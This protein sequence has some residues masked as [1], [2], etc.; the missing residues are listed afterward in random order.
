MLVERPASGLGDDVAGSG[1]YS[2]VWGGFGRGYEFHTTS[3][4][5]ISRD[6]SGDCHAEMP[7][8]SVKKST[9]AV[10]QQRAVEA[11]RAAGLKKLQMWVPG[12]KLDAARAAVSA[13]IGGRNAPPEPFQVAPAISPE[14][15]EQLKKSLETAKNLKDDWRHRAMI[16]EARR[17]WFWWFL[18]LLLAGLAVWGWWPTV[19]GWWS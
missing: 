9:D 18:A 6:I 11:K 5:Y 14:E 13:V 16:A 17:P 12:L 1:A 15:V 7:R 3:V 8:K 4:R 10:R 19:A 2:A